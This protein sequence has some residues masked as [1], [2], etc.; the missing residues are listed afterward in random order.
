MICLRRVQ[1]LQKRFIADA[2]QLITHDAKCLYPGRA[3]QGLV[4]EDLQ[5]RSH[6]IE[7]RHVTYRHI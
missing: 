1:Y 5:A 7:L 2:H 3:G 6:D 4:V